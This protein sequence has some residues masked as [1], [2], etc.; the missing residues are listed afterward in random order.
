MDPELY[1]IN[2]YDEN[3]EKAGTFLVNKAVFKKNYIEMKSIQYSRREIYKIDAHCFDIELGYA[4]SKLTIGDSID[5]E[6]VEEY[7]SEVREIYAL[8]LIND[9]G[10]KNWIY[11]KKEYWLEYYNKHKE[12]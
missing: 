9:T 2:V 10:Q 1:A 12:K 11:V 7:Q 6:T 4:K 5:F 3:P 8:K